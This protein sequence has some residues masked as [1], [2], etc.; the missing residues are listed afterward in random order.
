ME[1][2]GHS[3]LPDR[4][5][6]HPRLRAVHD[7]RED[8]VL[9]PAGCRNYRWTG[10]VGDRYLY[11]LAGIECVG[12]DSENH[13]A[14]KKMTNGHKKIKGCLRGRKTAFLCELYGRLIP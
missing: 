11:L 3:H 14:E 5:V 4:D 8:P 10:D 6:D 1:R 9:V 12:D 13:T 7:R 2:E